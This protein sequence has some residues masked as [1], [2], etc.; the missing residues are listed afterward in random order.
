V[1]SNKNKNSGD[2][3]PLH[4]LRLGRA[5]ERKKNGLSRQVIREAESQRP[6]ELGNKLKIITMEDG[7]I[8]VSILVFIVS[9]ILFIFNI[10]WM[11]KM[12]SLTKQ[13]RI[14]HS[15]TLKTI[16]IYCESKGLTVDIQKIQKEVEES[17]DP[18]PNIMNDPPSEPGNIVV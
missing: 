4:L 12:L 16:L 3:N 2:Q 10:Y 7:V 8:K 5:A 14:I 18:D 13:S 9:L 11:L 1:T 15:M 17:M 6:N